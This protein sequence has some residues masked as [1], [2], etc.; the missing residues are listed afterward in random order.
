MKEELNKVGSEIENKNTTEHNENRELI[1]YRGKSSP[2]KKILTFIII[3]PI[4]LFVLYIGY[5]YA[6]VSGSVVAIIVTILIVVGLI[7]MYVLMNKPPILFDYEDN[8]PPEAEKLD[9]S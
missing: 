5:F 1:P 7:K 2:L 3:G 9:F 8:I 4:I 6:V